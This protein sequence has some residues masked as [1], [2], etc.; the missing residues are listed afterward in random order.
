MERRRPIVRHGTVLVRQFPVLAHVFD[1]V[2]VLGRLDALLDVL[3][4]CEVRALKVH[5]R[6]RVEALV[7]VDNTEYVACQCYCQQCAG[8]VTCKYYVQ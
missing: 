7:L 4:V 5:I 6:D 3:I 1:G 8:K 2:V